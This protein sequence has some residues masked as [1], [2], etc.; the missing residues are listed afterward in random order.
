MTKLNVNILKESGY[1]GHVISKK[2][3]KDLDNRLYT[4]IHLIGGFTTRDVMFFVDQATEEEMKELYRLVKIF[5]SMMQ[6]LL[7]L[8]G[9]Y[10]ML[11]QTEIYQEI[12]DIIKFNEEQTELTETNNINR[13][14]DNIEQ[15]ISKNPYLSNYI[16]E[17]GVRALFSIWDSMGTPDYDT[18]KLVGINSD[19]LKY[20]N[21]DFHNISDIVWPLLVIEWEGGIQNTKFAKMGYSRT[22]EGGWEY[23]KFK[24]EPISYDYM[25][26]ESESFGEYGYACWDIRILIDKTSDLSLPVNKEFIDNDYDYFIQ[27]LFPESARNKLSSFRNY[28]D[29]QLET[30][31]M[32]WEHYSD[33]VD[34]AHTFCRVEVVL[35][36][37]SDFE[38]DTL[39]YKW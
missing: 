25:F 17:K 8:A 10:R 20:E 9:S 39:E 15:F 33:S 7:P 24:V 3:P 5:P 31:E 13:K 19:E 1:Y 28:T 16:S 4:M 37:D 6:D 14:V 11:I 29:D 12:I 27:E 38:K 23:L 34:F 30:I 35:V 18:M 26:D 2:M 22:N 21:T 36:D 32:M